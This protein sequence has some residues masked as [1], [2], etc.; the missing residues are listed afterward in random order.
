MEIIVYIIFW[1]IIG[2]LILDINEMNI[3]KY[4]E[5]QQHFK[6]YLFISMPLIYIS[7]K[8]YYSLKKEKKNV[9]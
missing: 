3:L 2:F 7:S 4:V 9:Q 1:H 6:F 5:N 8:I